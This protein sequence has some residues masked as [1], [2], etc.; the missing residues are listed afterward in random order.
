MRASRSSLAVLLGLAVLLSGCGLL[1]PPTTATSSGQ[2]A[3]V[4]AAPDARPSSKPYNIS[5]L[6]HPAAGKYL[7][8]EADG[9]PDS[10][11][12][13]ESFAANTG[14]KPNL[15]GQY[16]AWGKPFDTQAVTNAWSYGA[17]YYMAW[18]PFGTT[19]SS[20][21]AGTSDGYLKRFAQA[22]H[23]FGAPVGNLSSAA[24][25]QDFGSSI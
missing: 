1:A 3:A 16:L 14:R 11:A 5:G 2:N 18:E 10:L 19:V 21:A 9:A 7:G 22:V 6:L 8:L 15:I 4:S 13:V 17:L 20:I 23:A 12:P 24:H 25:K